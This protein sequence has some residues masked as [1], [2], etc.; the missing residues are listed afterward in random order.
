MFSSS[1]AVAKSCVR[2]L[3][4]LKAVELSIVQSTK[5]CVAEIK[6]AQYKTVTGDEAV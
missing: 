6:A 4:S 5:Q 1:D 2:V 3:Q